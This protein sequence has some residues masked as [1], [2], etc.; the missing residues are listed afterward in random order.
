MNYLW[1]TLHIRDVQRSLSF[2][3]DLL[4]MRV[5]SHS[6]GQPEIIMLGEAGGPLLELLR[7]EYLPDGLGKGM[8]VGYQVDDLDAYLAKARAADY[9]VSEPFVLPEMRFAFVT[10]P[11]GYQVQL[12]Q[13]G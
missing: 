4:G 12:V 2:Y 5:D 9:A 3:R 10:D 13:M 11:D 8:S 1:T 6:K 7:D